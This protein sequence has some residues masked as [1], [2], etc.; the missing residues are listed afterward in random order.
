MHISE[1]LSQNINEEIQSAK[2][3]NLKCNNCTL[4]ELAIIKELINDPG[5]TQKDLAIKIGKSER[6]IKTRT[7]ELQKKG[8]ICHENSKRNG[9]WKV[10]VGL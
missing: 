7:V 6:T 5:I 3:D 1:I 2:A 4:E 10:L 8:L 9:K